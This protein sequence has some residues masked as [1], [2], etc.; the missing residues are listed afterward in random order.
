VH[1]LQLL[2]EVTALGHPIHEAATLGDPE[3]ERLLAQ[4]ATPP[5]TSRAAVGAKS[6]HPLCEDYIDAIG[7]FEVQRAGR[8]LQR[9]AVLLSRDEFLFR[10]VLPILREVG[11]RWERRKLG[12]AHEHLV[13]AQ[14]RALLESDLR[15][16]TAAPGAP[17]IVIATPPGEEH[18]FGALMGALVAGSRG[19]EVVYLGA[20]LPWEEIALAIE[21]SGAAFVL[22]GS[23]RE[24]EADDLDDCA[25]GLRQ[26]AKGRAEVWVGLPPGHRLEEEVA[27]PRYFVSFEE[28]DMALVSAS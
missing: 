4:S 9:A 28:L 25:R 19:F 10:V 22:L 23:L 24:L 5:S 17:K 3:L 27:G 15:L 1:R 8:L 20:S 7:R 13:S 2:Q 14:V 16:S 21:M 12:V 18:E 6:F 11:N 26:L